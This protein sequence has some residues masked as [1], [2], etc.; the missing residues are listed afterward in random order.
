M[1]N[2]MDLLVWKKAHV[3]TLRLYEATEEFPKKEMFGLTSQI[4]RSASS[5]GANLAEGCGRRGNAEMARFVR[6]AMG[7][8]SELEYHLLLAADLKYLDRKL[9]SEIQPNLA[10]VRSMLTGLL[11]AIDQELFRGKAKSAKAGG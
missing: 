7:S 6:I 5:I 11:E 3:L 1:R 8:A 2:F 10:E 4:R 9:Y